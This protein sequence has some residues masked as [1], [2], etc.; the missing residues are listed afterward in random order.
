MRIESPGGD[1]DVTQANLSGAFLGGRQ[2]ERRHAERLAG[3]RLG[4][5][6]LDRSPRGGLR[7]V[8]RRSR[9]RRPGSVGVEQA[10]G[11]LVGG[12]DAEGHLQHDSPVR[13]KSKGDDGDVKQVNASAA[14]SAA[15]NDNE[16]T[17]SADE[18]AGWGGVN[19]Q[20]LGQK[21]WNGQG[22]RFPTPTSQQYDPEQRQRAR[23]GSTARAAVAEVSAG[24]RLSLGAVGSGRPATRHA[25]VATPGVRWDS[26]GSA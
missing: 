2:F 9:H 19:V 11:R 17:Q 15:G 7:L 4:L 18:A 13:I 12:L 6:V 24:Q 26:P 5:P 25:R 16:T 14:K 23:C 1:G 22:T 10:V 8:R 3:R 20:A 21:A